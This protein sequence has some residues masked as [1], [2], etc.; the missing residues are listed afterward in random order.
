[1]MFVMKKGVTSNPV[2]VTLAGAV[3]IV[4]E[5]YSVMDLVEEPLGPFFRIRGIYG[6]GDLW[7][8]LP[9]IRIY[10]K[11]NSLPLQKYIRNLCD[12]FHCYNSD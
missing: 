12:F 2:N 9:H 6:K 11:V 3:G 4:L 5:S 7:T 1:M 8:L 10:L